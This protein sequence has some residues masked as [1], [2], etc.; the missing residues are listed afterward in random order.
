MKKIL[1]FLL[2]T[3]FITTFIALNTK[4]KVFANNTIEETQNN[5]LVK[6]VSDGDV[7]FSNIG[8]D[9]FSQ[10]KNNTSGI[11]EYH[12]TYS[13]SANF[14]DD[15]EYH[16][17]GEND[18]YS[19]S[20]NLDTLPNNYGVVTKHIFLDNYDP[21]AEF[22]IAE[23]D[24]VEIDV[25]NSGNASA[26]FYSFNN[27]ELL[28]NYTL[29]MTYLEPTIDIDSNS[30][31][32][33]ANLEVSGRKYTINNS[34]DVSNLL[35]NEKEIIVNNI[36][37]N[38][39]QAEVFTTSNADDT[40]GT[41]DNEMLS[42]SQGR[43]VV[44]YTLSDNQTVND[45]A[46]VLARQIA[47]NLV[48]AEN[49][50]VNELGFQQAAGTSKDEPNVYRVTLNICH[51][52]T[53]NTLTKDILQAQTDNECFEMI[54]ETNY[55]YRTSIT[56]GVYYNFN[57]SDILGNRFNELLK[58][59]CAHEYFHAI[60]SMKGI[61]NKLLHE[62]LASF[63]GLYYCANYLNL[64]NPLIK[65]VNTNRIICC[66][67]FGDGSVVDNSY[68]KS[69]LEFV[70]PT[71]RDWIYEYGTMLFHIFLYEK[72]GT[73]DFVKQLID[74]FDIENLYHTY[75]YVPTLYNTT[76]SNLLEEYQIYR[77]FPNL[78]VK[79][80]DNY[81]T[82]DWKMYV[83]EDLRTEN[84]ISNQ[85]FE[86][87]SAQYVMFTG[88]QILLNDSLYL[89]MTLNE[90]ISEKIAIYTVKKRGDLPPVVKKISTSENRITI[91]VDAVD[92][93]DDEEMVVIFMNLSNTNISNWIDYDITDQKKRVN[94]T[95]TLNKPEAEVELNLTEYSG[96]IGLDVPSVG[97]HE[98]ELELIS[99]D[100]PLQKNTMEL[101]GFDLNIIQKCEYVSDEARTKS[102][103]N[104]LFVYLDST[105]DISMN[106]KSIYR[107]RVGYMYANINCII[108][109]KKVRNQTP[110]LGGA[111]LTKEITLNNLSGDEVNYVKTNIIGDLN[112]TFTAS[113]IEEP[114][115]I[116][117]IKK[118][119]VE[120][121]IEDITIKTLT[122]DNP[123]IQ[124]SFYTK[125]YED[126]I[127]VI[128]S[129]KNDITIN[130][131]IDAR[132][133]FD[134]ILDPSGIDN[135]YLG[136][137]VRLN[138][139]LNNDTTITRGFTRCAYLGTNAP[140]TS[141]LNYTWL[142]SD[143]R[144]ATVSSYGT[145][146][147][148]KPGVAVI[149]AT[150]SSGKSSSVVV[151]VIED[152]KQDIVNFEISTDLGTDTGVGTYVK[153]G[154]GLPGGTDL[155]YGY[156]RIISLMDDAPSSI[157]Q[158]YDWSS[159]D[160]YIAYV[161]SY[162]TIIGKGAGTATITGVYKYNHRYVTTITVVVS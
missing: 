24:N 146:L 1:S 67:D 66:Y 26:K 113:N 92:L 7:D 127:I 140:S 77:K 120:T 139:G 84:K 143:E 44:S 70:P 134:I 107:L 62:S 114:Q 86:K 106:I 151:E 8:I 108:R 150:N 74:N 23:I 51:D 152:E 61:N 20:I 38:N 138:D 64:K 32:Y 19:I 69:T 28:A 25:D 137:E 158:H 96:F 109:I 147:A 49:Y 18:N 149:T 155:I 2:T 56:M 43:F 10:V 5:Y 159:S 47:N 63:M 117:I 42:V 154:L 130:Y 103:E 126:F 17:I 48:E 12:D 9:I 128:L 71:T 129:G 31:K 45:K 162:G 60:I 29:K 133:D 37:G 160:T 27:R 116:L 112:V 132:H 41:T 131:N 91:R 95:L 90:T 4:S 135:A 76:L 14:S 124:L 53:F 144:I 93:K 83:P 123:T 21:I 118:R 13:H 99:G 6:I 85:K 79:A 88:N 156:T 50:F 142:S 115:K 52:E 97:W 59:M 94:A 16:F 15:G 136:T 110:T 40:E 30:M 78:F 161:S 98:I 105:R 36:K 39:F 104:K 11:T 33:V 148:I 111:E 100:Q 87:Y 102:G 75:E 3:I 68:I 58:E 65:A 119:R 55:F 153:G 81:Y 101:Y 46:V 157:L 89:T 54:D 145:I 72:F 34:I 35:D 57:R 80:I 82:E 22:I 73:L 121:L 141:R 125:T 122:T